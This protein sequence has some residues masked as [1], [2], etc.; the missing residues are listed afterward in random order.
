MTTLSHRLSSSDNSTVEN[1]LRWMGEILEAL[2]ESLSEDQF[3]TV[4]EHLFSLRKVK[5]VLCELCEPDGRGGCKFHLRSSRVIGI[6]LT[7]FGL[8]KP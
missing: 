4:A 2:K 7:P 3:Y 8:V 1:A 6:Q 5:A